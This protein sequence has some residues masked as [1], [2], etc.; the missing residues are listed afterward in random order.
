MFSQNYKK[1]KC[2]LRLVYGCNMRNDEEGRER[3]G[4][5]EAP[6]STRNCEISS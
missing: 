6:L 4:E 1:K 2:D 5:E 3:G